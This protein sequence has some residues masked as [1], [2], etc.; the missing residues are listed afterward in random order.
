MFRPQFEV[1]V[2]EVTGKNPKK[3]WFA[4]AKVAEKARGK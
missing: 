4:S 2:V 3:V 1:H